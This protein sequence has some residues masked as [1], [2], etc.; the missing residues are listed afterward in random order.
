[1]SRWDGLNNERCGMRGCGKK[2][3]GVWCG[4]MGRKE[5]SEMALA[6]LQGWEMRN[7]LRR[8]I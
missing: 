1:M 2:W 7:I 5:H 3:D 4:G 6:I 8:C